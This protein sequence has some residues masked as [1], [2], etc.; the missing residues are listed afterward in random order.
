MW[1]AD[2]ADA[3]L[4]DCLLAGDDVETVQP[5]ELDVFR[6]VYR[7]PGLE[8][9]VLSDVSCAFPPGRMSAVMG[10][11]GSGKTSLLTLLRGLSAPGSEMTGHVLCNARP[12]TAEQMRSCSGA[13][14]QEDS[15]LPGLTVHETL[16]FAAAL[17]LPRR[18]TKRNRARRVA[19]LMSDLQLD[20]CVDT[21]VG[22]ERLGLRGI[23]GG[24]RKRL[25]IATAL[26]GGLPSLLLCDEPTSGLDSAS[27]TII[28][29]LLRQLADKRVTV[30]CSIHQPSST[31]FHEFSF[32]LL[33]QAGKTTYCGKVLD[34]EAHFVRHGSPTPPHTSPAHHYLQEV[35][36]AGSQPWAERWQESTPP[37]AEATRSDAAPRG[38]SR[39]RRRGTGSRAGLSVRAQTAVLT[40]R[41]LVENFKNRKKFFRGVMMRLPASLVI[42]LIFWQVGARPAQGSV[43]T[44]KGVFLL[45]VQNPLIESFYAG[46]ASFQSGKGLLKRE[47][48]DGLY[49][50][51]AFY[52]SYYAGFAAM[53]LPWTVIWVLPM[54]FLT[55]MPGDPSV[56]LT[57]M[58]TA[59]LVI[60]MSCSWGS[61]V[62]AW[63]RDQDSARSVLLPLLVPMLLFSG[64]IIPYYQAPRLWR[65]LYFLSPV[66]WG[67]SILE[68]SYYAGLE[69]G[70]CDQ[71]VPQA[72]RTCFA[73]G[74]EYL[75]SVGHC[76]SVVQMLVICVGYTVAFFVLNAYVV[77]QHVLNG[78][79]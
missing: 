22:D 5:A 15:F 14:P 64:Y 2:I 44:I 47:Y 19:K 52:A 33:L 63:A 40:R 1:T 10:A 32:L 9:P 73:T 74:E 57:F 41:A 62:G 30:V 55:G 8:R 50:A 31:I 20:A 37:I 72:E 24:E 38:A 7:V 25:S 66:Q 26:V 6:I 78:R 11:S 58:L 46:A 28:I 53:Q 17:R 75:Q 12:V 45:C 77:R 54:Y 69:F 27:A 60:L 29:G 16:H 49:S 67:V 23:S 51:R 56:L 61:S 21:P 36:S 3:S 4:A 59:F 42:G 65:P 34:V 76:F 43:N 13:V 70:D 35:A 18:W 68:V 79:V 39:A 71:A 48:Y